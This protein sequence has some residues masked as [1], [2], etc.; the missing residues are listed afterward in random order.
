MN[1]VCKGERP[2]IPSGVP[3]RYVD[4]IT[5]CWDENPDIRPTFTEICDLLESDEFLNDP[6]I[7]RD[8]FEDYKKLVY[9]FRPSKTHEKSDGIRQKIIEQLDDVDSLKDQISSIQKEAKTYKARA[10]ESDEL[11]EKLTKELKESQNQIKKLQQ[12]SSQYVIDESSTKEGNAFIDNEER[13]NYETVKKIG[14][15]ATSI[16]YKIV[17]TRTG[18]NLCKKVLKI[19]DESSQFT[20]AKNAMKE[21]ETL[22]T[23]KHPCICRAIGI[24]TS[25]PINEDDQTNTTIALYLEFLSRNLKECID[26]N[27]LDNT[28]KVRI[29]IETAHALNFIHKHGMIHRD[30][31]IEN[32]MMNSI[33]EN[34]NFFII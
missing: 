12:N 21:F 32:I 20:N 25:E 33:F 4:L 5:S 17:D 8:L 18:E 26:K 11:V 1:A 22:Y 31:K 27:I 30:I 34:D 24:N 2:E 6:E 16:V 13:K 10:E 29:A 15:G 23:I 28:L 19:S 3:E 9:P 14:E 7:D